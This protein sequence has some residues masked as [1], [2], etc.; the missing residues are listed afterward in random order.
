M[1]HNQPVFSLEELRT[2]KLF[3]SF[4]LVLFSYT[5]DN[6]LKFLLH[7]TP[8][9]K[10]SA[11]KG[12]VGREPCIIYAITK[13]LIKK[14][15]GLLCTQNYKWIKADSKDDLDLA[16]IIRDKQYESSRPAISNSE[17]LLDCIRT[18]THT[19]FR[20]QEDESNCGYF[21]VEVPLLD[22]N[23]LQELNET[24]E[25]KTKYQY[26]D[27]PSLLEEKSDSVNPELLD[28]ISKNIKL[29]TYIDK[30]LVKRE[31]I[32]YTET[33][34]Y[35]MCGTNMGN[36]RLDGLYS[37]FFRKHGERWLTF[38]PFLGQ[39]PTEN[40]IA[41]AKGVIVPGSVACAYNPEAYPWLTKMYEI[42]KLIV[43][44]YPHINY[45]GICFG[46]QIA[47]QALGGKVENMGKGLIRGGEVFYPK[48]DFYKL[49][50][51]QKL[52]IDQSKP[53]SI[54]EAHED[55]IRKLPEGAI[56]HADSETAPVE[57]YTL[58][59]NLLG[60]QGHPDYSETYQA[61][62]SY[63]ARG[64]TGDFEKYEA[65]FIKED[66]KSVV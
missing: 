52:D 61:A 36:G 50:Y 20:F 43:E 42:I 11:F 34:V 56:L 66:R 18:L 22:L 54:A 21:F 10:Y 60:W 33:Y 14:T 1:E 2:F 27:Y 39:Y 13:E 37:S 19:P 16:S 25:I 26:F 9:Y 49:P 46:A 6:K 44:K 40:E 28:M 41:Q 51:I 32:E 64:L 17:A 30:F 63:A 45:L 35:L 23:R 58:G 38:Y 15:G 48:K 53:I 47:A 62:R 55:C 4:F 8:D 24:F 65:E 57:I 3:D 5:E 59:N 31:Q 12:N 29:R 7:N